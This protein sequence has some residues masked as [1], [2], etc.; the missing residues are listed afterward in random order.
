MPP[1][2][3]PLWSDPGLAMNIAASFGE[4]AP[5]PSQ[6]KIVYRVAVRA[7]A[8][9]SFGGLPHFESRWSD[10]QQGLASDN[11][12]FLGEEATAPGDVATLGWKEEENKTYREA[13]VA[14]MEAAKVT[15]ASARA[16]RPRPFTGNSWE[17]DNPAVPKKV[18]FAD[19]HDIG[20][21]SVDDDVDNKQQ[22]ACR[23]TAT[24][25]HTIPTSTISTL[26]S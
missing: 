21:N 17:P 5:Q 4:E 18:R 26:S 14:A 24:I 16:N 20:D 7:E 13:A 10:Q 3:D 2:P 15:T 12:A 25:R 11:T 9:K 23:S 1:L 22:Q 6:E 19:A 8:A